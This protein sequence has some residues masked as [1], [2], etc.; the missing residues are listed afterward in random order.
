MRKLIFSILSVAILLISQTTSQAQMDKKQFG[1]RKFDHKNIVKFLELSPEQE[2]KFNDI[3]YNHQK[4]MI[5]LHTQIQKNRLEFKNL[6]ANKDI[7]EKEIISLT[8]DNSKLQSEIKKSTVEKWL[9]VYKILNDDQKE[10]WMLH[11]EGFDV[12]ERIR[13][14][15]KERFMERRGMGK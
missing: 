10:K 15:M 11:L 4:E 8:E 5:E 7:N 6:F 13:E 3:N 1:D 2:K 12:R 14:G 9:S